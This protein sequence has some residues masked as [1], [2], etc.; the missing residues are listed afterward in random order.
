[1]T[2]GMATE[3]MKLLGGS[4]MSAPMPSSYEN[5][6]KKV[7]DGMAANGECIIGFRLYEVA[8]YYTIIPTTCVTQELI[9][10]KKTWNKLP[11]DVQIA[12][13][14]VSG[15]HAAIRFGGGCFDRAWDNLPELVKKSGYEMITYTPPK[16]EVDR[17]VEIAGK[18]LWEAWIKKM[19]SLGYSNA[20]AIQEE[21]VRLV[22]YYSQGK[23]DTWK[24]MF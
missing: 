1:M 11:A 3:M 17:W 22:D 2:G 24:E 6:Q 9:M 7:I 19:E 5:L 21:M 20:R 18:P 23:T 8:K 15:E 13:M 14:S 12:I 16:E 4:P 10:N